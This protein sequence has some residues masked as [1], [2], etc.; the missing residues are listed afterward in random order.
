MRAFECVCVCARACAPHVGL[1][2]V[3]AHVCMCARTP[4]TGSY[5][6]GVERIQ[7]ETNRVRV[8]ASKSA[9][10]AAAVRVRV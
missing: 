1:C 2:G 3:C 9:A 5:L 10:R 6:R 4:R 7:N 8:V